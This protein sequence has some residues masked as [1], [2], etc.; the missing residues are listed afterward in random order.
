VGITG[1]WDR[2][3]ARRTLL[4][5][6]GSLAAGMALAGALAPRALAGPVADGP[7]LPIPGYPFT[8]GVASG[9]LGPHSVVLWTR[10][11]PTP[12]APDGGM[13][14]ERFPVRVELALDDQFHRIVR[15]DTVW[16]VPDEAHSARAEVQG[17]DPA[18]EYFNRFKAGRETSPVG[19]TRT[20]PELGA[21]LESLRFAFVSCQNFPVGYFNAYADVVAQDLDAVIHLGDYIYEYEGPGSELRE[22]EPRTKITTL[23]DYRIRQAQYKTDLDLQ[24][25]HAAL[26]WLV[27]WD[28]HEVENNYADMDSD[29]DLPPEEFALRREYAYRAYWEHMPLRRVRKPRRAFFNLYRRFRWGTMATFNVLDTRQYRSDQPRGC[30]VADRAAG[31]GYCP[32]ALEPNRTMLGRDQREWLFEDLATTPSRWNVLAQQTALSP[33]DRNRG[34]GRDRLRHGGQVGRLPRRAAAAPRLARGPRDAEPRRDHRR[35]PRELGPQRASEPK[36][37]GRASRCHGVHGDVDLQRRRSAGAVRPLPGRPAEPP[38]RVPQQQPRLRALHA[39]GGHVGERLPDRADGPRARGPGHDA[40][41]L[42]GR[43]RPARGAARRHAGGVTR[44]GLRPQR[45]ARPRARC[46][47]ARRASRT[48]GSGASRPS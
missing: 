1:D 36:G 29:P 39:H 48:R 27:T 26:P 21:T 5:T 44:A 23:D 13:P 24:A 18:W 6:G 7:R 22:H 8:L 41:R 30:Q 14:D 33:W 3:I 10:L 4:R 40:G 45:P 35:L 20:A 25:A 31:A 38:R 42:R 15:R 17:L 9:D 11:A 16:A 32:G 34:S 37:A 19:R 43:E 12:L 46:A 2:V 28:D 47:G